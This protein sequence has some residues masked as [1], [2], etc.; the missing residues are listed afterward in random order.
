MP[1]AKWSKL[2]QSQSSYA[3]NDDSQEL[4]ELITNYFFLFDCFE[5]KIIF[6]NTSFEVVTGYTSTDFTLE[7]LLSI[8]HPE[9]LE[10][11]YQSEENGLHFTNKLLFNDHYKFI[12]SYSYR[13]R[14]ADGSYI[15]INQQCQGIEV[16]TQGHLT[17][18]LVKHKVINDLVSQPENDYK[19][20]DKI[21]NIFVDADNCFRL[22]KRE[23]EI[24]DL[25]R[26]GL[27]SD[28]IAEQLFLSR[29]T[30]ITHRRNIL[31]K[32]NSSSFFELFK[33]MRFETLL[34]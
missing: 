14:I 9:D 34:G 28:Q 15:W 23:L 32:A 20:Y 24:I 3:R 8:I 17:K 5:N 19:I 1:E 7:F 29:N 6:T 2:V 4:A 11:F 18:T 31:N 33:K 30:I 12:L 21:K 22:T 13:I 25:I 10:Y 27:S 16:N 26:E